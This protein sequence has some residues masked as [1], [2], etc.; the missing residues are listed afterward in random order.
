MDTVGF[1]ERINISGYLKSNCNK[2]L[3]TGKYN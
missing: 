3:R 2:I 1:D